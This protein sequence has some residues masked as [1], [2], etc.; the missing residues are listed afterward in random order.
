MRGRQTAPSRYRDFMPNRWRWALVLAAATALDLLARFAT[1][2]DFG[3]VMHAEAVLFPV[4]GIA[5]AILLRRDPGTRPWSHTIR[6]ALVWLFA[7]GGLRPVLWSLGAPMM[8]ANLATLFTALVG[9]VAWIV[10]RRRQA[11]DQPLGG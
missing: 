8:A 4:T 10:R 2:F 7:L 6:V 5:L 3:R 1:S 11:A 9:L